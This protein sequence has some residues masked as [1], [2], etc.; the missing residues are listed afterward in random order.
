MRDVPA[1]VLHRGTDVLAWNRAAAALLTDFGAQ[2]SAERD[3]IRLTFLDPILHAESAFLRRR[4]NPWKGPSSRRGKAS[5][6]FYPNLSRTLS[7]TGQDLHHDF[8]SRVDRAHRSA[9]SAAPVLFI[10][11][12]MCFSTVRGR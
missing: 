6:R 9:R 5:L 2:P 4:R 11:L 7:E 12:A 3:P 1:M 8:V 10:R